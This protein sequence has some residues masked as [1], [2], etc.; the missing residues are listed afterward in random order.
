MEVAQGILSKEQVLHFNGYLEDAPEDFLDEDQ[1]ELIGS[2]FEMVIE[3]TIREW[4]VE[5]SRTGQGEA[6]Q[7][8]V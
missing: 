7:R 5:D 4:G 6:L 2:I 8:I 1:T 3:H